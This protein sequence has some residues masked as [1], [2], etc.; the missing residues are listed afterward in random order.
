MTNMSAVFTGVLLAGALTVGTAFAQQAGAGGAQKADPAIVKISDAYLAAVKARD[1]AKVV[2]LYKEDAVE[3]PPHQK[4][5]RGRA[6]IQAYYQQ[7]FKG[8]QAQFSDLRLQR[9][10]ARTS[11]DVGYDTGQY[12]QRITPRG[13]KPIDDSGNYIVILHQTG[14]QWRVAHVIY[15]S[16]LPPM[17][18]PGQ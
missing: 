15:N 13:G 11:G 10:E 5:V 4:P 3:M 8:E 12:S 9:T 18:P 16:H 6:N 14:G 17:A 2:E 7:Q 1:A